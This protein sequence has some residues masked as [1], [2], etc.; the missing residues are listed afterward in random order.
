VYLLAFHARIN[1]IHGSRGKIPS[2]KSRQVGFNSGVKGLNYAISF[3]FFTVVTL[4]AF[5]ASQRVST[6]AN[7]THLFYFHAAFGMPE[8]SH[9]MLLRRH[10]RPMREN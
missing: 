6:T 4:T 8:M 2:K 9:M 7:D 3:P 1:E 5:Q 10:D